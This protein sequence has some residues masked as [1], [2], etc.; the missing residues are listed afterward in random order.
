[1]RSRLGRRLDAVEFRLR[2][3]FPQAW[4]QWRNKGELPDNAWTRQQ[5]LGIETLMAAAHANSWGV[6]LA[7]LRVDEELPGWTDAGRAELHADI[8]RRVEHLVLCR[9]ALAG[10]DDAVAALALRDR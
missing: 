5:I 9:R 1:M 2:P 4:H 10:E 6:D 7:T 3:P 8:A